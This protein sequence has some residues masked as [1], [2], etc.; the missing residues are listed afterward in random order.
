MES[1]KGMIY[2]GLKAKNKLIFVF[3]ERK[4]AIK[5]GTNNKSSTLTVRA[6]G[7]GRGMTN[8]NFI[9]VRV[10]PDHHSFHQRRIYVIDAVRGK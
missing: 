2:K 4:G 6:R 8:L 10:T 5:R 7:G 1:L 3:T 9:Y